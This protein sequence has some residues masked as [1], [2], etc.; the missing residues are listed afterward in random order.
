[1]SLSSLFPKVFYLY[2]LIR[3][4]GKMKISVFGPKIKRKVEQSK[5]TRTLPMTGITWIMNQ[6]WNTEI[7][8][9]RLLYQYVWFQ[10][11]VSKL[12]WDIFKYCVFCC[13]KYWVGILYILNLNVS[14]TD[15]SSF[16]DITIS[17][18]REMSARLYIIENRMHNIEQVLNTSFR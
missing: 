7:P 8:Q 16:E 13:Y 15:H 3:E 4:S 6:L 1:M 14:V 9:L 10:K 17:R 18:G 2:L 11:F 5:E 12:F